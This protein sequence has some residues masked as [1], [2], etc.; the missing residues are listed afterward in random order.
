VV[1]QAHN[2]VQLRAFVLVVFR[3]AKL[4]PSHHYTTRRHNP[5]DHDS[6]FNNVFLKTEEGKCKVVPVLN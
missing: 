2:R 3:R 1:E 4:P 5:E 6:N